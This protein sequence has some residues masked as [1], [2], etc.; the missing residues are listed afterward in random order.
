MDYEYPSFT[1][2]GFGTETIILSKGEYVLLNMVD[3]TSHPLGK[4]SE[5]ARAKLREIKM[6]H[7][8]YLIP[9]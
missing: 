3:K 7:L 9:G 5:E 8:D 2:S 1:G 4:T 6:E